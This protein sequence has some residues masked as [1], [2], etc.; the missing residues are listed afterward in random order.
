MVEKHRLGSSWSGII[1]CDG[2]RKSNQTSKLAAFTA[3][4][5]G[6]RIA[7]NVNEWAG[8]IDGLC[9]YFLKNGVCSSPL[10]MNCTATDANSRP[11]MRV[12][13]FRASGLR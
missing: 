9:R 6:Q 4:D 12:T 1:H 2:G 3:L 7:A 11:K 13:S 5:E 8:R 10:M